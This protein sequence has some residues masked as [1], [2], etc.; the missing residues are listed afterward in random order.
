[1]TTARIYRGATVLAP[2]PTPPGTAVAVA[3]G[4]IVAVGPEDRCTA[5]LP[6]DAEVVDLDGRVLAPGFVDA[7][8][9]PLV[10]CVFET[11]LVLDR[12]GTLADV[13][14]AVADQARATAP[15]RTIVGFQLDDERLAER[16]L[17]TAAELDAA[18]AGR[19]V[20]L[21]RRDG[22]HAVA[23]S[24]AL[25]AVSYDRPGSDPA[26]GEVV[27]D[28]TGPTGLVRET[29]VAPLLG[30]MPDVTFEELE[31]GLVAWR[32]RLLA[33]GV[34]AISAMCQ[35][36]AEGPSGD[37]GAL[38]AVGWSALVDRVPFDVQTILI[39]PDVADVEQ[40][41]ARPLHR[42]GAGRRLDAV[43]LFLDGTLGGRTACMHQPY[44]D[45]DVTGLP[46]L[47][48]AEA[49][50]RVE[51]AHLAGLQVCIHAIGDRATRDA[52]AVLA[53]VVAA[54]PGPHRHRVEHASVLDDATVE[55]MAEVGVTAV[56]QP[57]SLRSESH[58]LARRIGPERLGRT[59]P[60]RRLLDAGV[61]V[62]GSSD[63]P[64]EATD[65]LAA[66]HAAVDRR[67][68]PEQALTGAEALA[69]HTRG[70]A[71]ARRTEDEFGSIAPGRR[72]DL[73]VLDR[74]PT[75]VPAGT[76]AS[77]RVLA[78]VVA[79]TVHHRHPDHPEL[80]P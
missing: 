23:S 72:A 41:R 70:G 38:E 27:R 56:V 67:I 50:R 10:M 19:A 11:S 14:D 53:E 7:H 52:V 2:E 69:L 25:A 66:M 49:R 8:L 26:G 43:K 65:V 6:S 46:T 58:W 16:R 47:A 68:A 57:I 22:H 73:V 3:D 54:H 44:A 29:A 30:L 20:V 32:D 12:A 77:T 17:P 1:M 74:D 39:T 59:Y 61:A 51:A 48:P 60:F 28:A 18:A 63:A 31:A 76:I 42:P 9:H 80:L 71:R 62:A 24:A 79:G 37:A 15:D 75:V 35:T 55:Q 21:L 64:I 33:Q 34:T 45:H 13:L 4:R 36:T 78:T 5:A 40:M